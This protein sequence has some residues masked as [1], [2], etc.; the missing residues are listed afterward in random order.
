MNDAVLLL[1]TLYKD[2][3][4]IYSGERYGDGILGDTIRTRD[5]W[6]TYWGDGGQLAPLLIL[7][8]M[9]GQQGLTKDGKLS[10]RCDETVKTYRYCVAEFDTQSRENQIRFWSAV[11][12]PIV[13]LIDSGGKSVHAW[14]EVS[15]L[16]KVETPEQWQSEIK[17]RL[18]DRL[19][20][21][22]GVDPACANPSRLSRLPG[23]YREEKQRY[24]RLLW[25]SPAGRSIC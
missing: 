22:M 19:L 23:H 7:N 13:A 25:L 14:L 5:E 24:Q 18:Y 9:T 4:L 12:L 3:D 16:A 10:F 8:P 21:P 11:K 15:K 1:E 2:D 17:G 20:V 6:I